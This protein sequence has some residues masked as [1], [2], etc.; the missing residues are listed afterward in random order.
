[1]KMC[2]CVL[3]IEPLCVWASTCVVSRGQCYTSW[4][5]Q[6]FVC[7][8]VHFS[9]RIR[10]QIWTFGWNCFRC[11]SDPHRSGELTKQKSV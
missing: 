7:T 10:T 3:Q 5:L 6:R 1:M 11:P 9:C 2:F 8:L 4:L